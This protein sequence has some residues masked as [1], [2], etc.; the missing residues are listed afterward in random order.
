[1][2][3]KIPC[4]TTLAAAISAARAIA[5]AR[6]LGEPPV[7]SLQELHRSL[8]SPATPDQARVA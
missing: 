1:V 3:H 4:L 8:R 2:A 6:A 5:R 7:L